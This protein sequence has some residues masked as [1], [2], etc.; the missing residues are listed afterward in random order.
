MKKIVG[1]APLVAVDAA[2]RFAFILL[3]IN[4]FGFSNDVDVY[5]ASQAIPLFVTALVLI[6]SQNALLPACTGLNRRQEQAGLV[7]ASLLITTAA[8]MLPMGLYFLASDRLFSVL[9]LFTQEILAHAQFTALCR[10][11]AI[12][13]VVQSAVHIMNTLFHAQRQFYAPEAFACLASI[14]C[15]ATYVS[16]DVTS[17]LIAAWI[18]LSRPALQLTGL[19]FFA[20][21]GQI[22]W[23]D[24]PAV[25]AVYRSYRRLFLSS[26]IYKSNIIWERMFS[27]MCGEGAIAIYTLLMNLIDPAIRLY[28]RVMKPIAISHAQQLVRRIYR[29][30]TVYALLPMAAGTAVVLPV[31]L[32]L[33]EDWF[34]T[35]LAG[36]GLG[37]SEFSALLWIMAGVIVGGGMGS[38]LTALYVGNHQIGRAHV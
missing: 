36:A 6:F 33:G 20:G 16:V 8:V 37:L 14:V 34:T 35:M 17:P 24:R 30:V 22:R 1:I 32:W 9:P 10:T 19:L 13:A 25:T 4:D 15:V 27:A 18:F 23:P 7:L 21:F 3:V 38:F 31:V 11:F 2:L 28:E 5:L 29:E 12:V 26:L